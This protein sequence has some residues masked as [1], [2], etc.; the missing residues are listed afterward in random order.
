[1]PLNWEHPRWQG[2][3]GADLFERLCVDLLRSLGFAKVEWRRGHPDEGWD[4]EAECEVVHPGGVRRETWYVQCKR[5][6]PTTGV[7]PTKIDTK[8]IEMQDKK[9]DCLLVMTSS[10][11]LPKVRDWARASH[12]YRVELWDG[13]ALEQLL[14]RSATLVEAYFPELAVEMKDSFLS[15]LVHTLRSSLQWLYSELS[16]TEDLVL[17]QG[18]EQREETGQAF[19]CLREAAENTSRHVE[20]FNIASQPTTHSVACNRGAFDIAATLSACAGTFSTL[21][22]RV[23]VRLLLEGPE[24]LLV[25]GDERAMRTALLDVFDNAIKY[26]DSGTSVE[27]RWGQN[28]RPPLVTVQVSNRG[29]GIPPE[30]IGKV[31]QKYYRC[32]SR[33]ARRFLPGTGIGLAIAKRVVEEH[34]G[35]ISIRS[36]KGREGDDA[37]LTCVTVQLPATEGDECAQPQ[38]T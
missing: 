4:I 31:F 20:R 14:P 16:R 36:E 38:A 32:H 11:F 34:G 26:A 22:H 1:M 7:P 27:A 19:H 3:E 9:P 2:Q 13:E 10:H 24:H 28:M 12:P 25:H 18:G 33:D 29:I 8:R 5:Y 23:N 21:A 17:R 6:A 37:W 15:L 35:R 30:E